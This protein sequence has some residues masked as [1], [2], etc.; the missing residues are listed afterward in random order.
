[1]PLKVSKKGDSKKRTPE[2]HQDT[3]EE[4]TGSITVSGEDE[5][6]TEEEESIDK[7]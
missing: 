1:V 2:A 6:T 7:E 5:M 3:Y 4:D